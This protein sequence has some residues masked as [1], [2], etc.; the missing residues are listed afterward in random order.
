MSDNTQT[1]NENNLEMILL[2]PE[3]LRVG[4]MER[5]IENTLCRVVSEKLGLDPITITS[6]SRIAEDLGADSLDIFQILMV[7]FMKSICFAKLFAG[8]QDFHTNG[9]DSLPVIL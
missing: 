9:L 8:G 6:S 5:K 2:I 1:L 4:S 7:I 3:R